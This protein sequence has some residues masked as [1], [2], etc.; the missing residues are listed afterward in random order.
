MSLT[1]SETNR[2]SAGEAE[3]MWAYS[4]F[5]IDPGAWKNGRQ[6]GIGTYRCGVT[7]H[8]Y[9]GKWVGGVRC[10]RGKDHSGR[11]PSVVM[12]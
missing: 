5:S 4:F 7:R 6:N 10:G 8:V 1:A 9:T 2:C 12:Y 3:C 11:I